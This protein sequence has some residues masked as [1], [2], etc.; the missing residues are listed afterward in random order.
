MPTL[1]KTAD[2]LA[3]T[4]AADG[5]IPNNPRLPVL[6]YRGAIDL[7]ETP[8]PEVVVEK[9]FARHGWGGMW[10]DGIYPYVHY[11]S[12]I[13]EAPGIARGRAK[14]RFGGAHGEV[15]EIGPGDVVVLPAGT[16]HQ[17]LWVAPEL[18]VIG[19]YPGSG[20]FDICRGSKS[21][22]ARAVT[23]IPEVPLPETD[24]V[25]GKNGPLLRLWRG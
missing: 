2:P 24:P 12:M 25:H 21:E 8:D 10:R 20:K 22:Y 16:G 15:L 18:V 4:F 17:A 23:T 14:V 7:S 5:S 9:A 11:H 19:A 13:Y 3:F 1:A 6:A